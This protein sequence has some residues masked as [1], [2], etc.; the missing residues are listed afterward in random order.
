[1]TPF[2][3]DRAA[4]WVQCS[5]IHTHCLDSIVAAVWADQTLLGWVSYLQGQSD[6]QGQS[7]FVAVASVEHILLG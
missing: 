3:F 4:A 5:W 7:V 6:L 2:G 1:M